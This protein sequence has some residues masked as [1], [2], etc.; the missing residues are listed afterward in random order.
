[1]ENSRNYHLYKNIKRSY[2][3]SI[4]L[5][6]FRHLVN[7]VTGN[8]SSLLCKS[9]QDVDRYKESLLTTQ[10]ISPHL[11]DQIGNIIMNITDVSDEVTL[12]YKLFEENWTKIMKDLQKLPISLFSFVV[13][14]LHERAGQNAMNFTKYITHEVD[15]IHNSII[16]GSIEMSKYYF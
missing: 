7:E 5:G 11:S 10:R 16:R 6:T 13:P 4:E 15:K 2:E 1:M 8:M 14:S 3:K 12:R 9:L